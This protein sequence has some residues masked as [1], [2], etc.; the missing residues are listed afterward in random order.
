MAMQKTLMGTALAVIAV[1]MMASVLALLQSS[2]TVP[3]SGTVRTVNV[4]VY[5]DNLCTQP[6]LSINWGTVDPGTSVLKTVYVKNQGSV[7]MTLNMTT[8]SWSSSNAQAYMTLTWDKETAS[9]APGNN[10]Q[11]TLNLTVLPAITGVTD[12]SFNIVITGTT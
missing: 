8:N 4:G 2:R 9:V 11:A 6:L 10:V 1:L 3:T 5:Q 7:S 12:F